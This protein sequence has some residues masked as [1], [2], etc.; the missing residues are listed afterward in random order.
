METLFTANAI[1]ITPS[2]KLRLAFWNSGNEAGFTVVCR[3]QIENKDGTISQNVEQFAINAGALDQQFFINLAYGN[4]LAVTLAT[5]GTTVQSGQIY[6]TISLQYGSVNDNAQ[7][8]PLISGYVLANAPL[9]YPLGTTQ[10]INSGLPATIEVAV[11]DPPPG[12]DF[13]HQ[14]APA[15]RSRLVHG[16]F[17]LVTD[18][19]A[20]NRTVTVKFANTSG[21]FWMT[22]SDTV[23]IASETKRYIYSPLPI[24]AVKPTDVIYLPIP[25]FSVT[26]NLS[27]SSQTANIQAGDAYTSQYILIERYVAM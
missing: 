26:Q 17:E 21:I 20:G 24:P 13:T 11:Q 10:A 18:A 4:L 1:P 27:I 7:Q 16:S 6:A 2:N 8:L 9:N 19:N 5:F 12:T 23:Q 25:Y 14:E 15:S 22:Q 3:Y